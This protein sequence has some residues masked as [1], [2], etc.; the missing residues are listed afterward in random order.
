MSYELKQNRYSFQY[1]DQ[2]GRDIVHNIAMSEA[3]T[4]LDVHEAFCDFLTAIYGW[5]TR[6]YFDENTTS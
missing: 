1:I 3:A 6:K 2:H 5:D 4:P